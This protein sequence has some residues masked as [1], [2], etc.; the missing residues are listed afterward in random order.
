MSEEK[1]F[2]SLKKCLDFLTI[3]LNVEAF[4]KKA[5]LKPD[6]TLLRKKTL[7][8]FCMLMITF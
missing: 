4:D 6:A 3:T 2:L 8:L 5:N 7:G 1:V